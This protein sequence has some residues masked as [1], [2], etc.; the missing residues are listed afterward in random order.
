MTLR[1]VVIHLRLPFSLFLLPVYL[2]GLFLPSAAGGIDALLVGIALHLFLYPASNAFNSFYDRD[3]GPI[4]GIASPPPV[5]G[6]LL[7]VSLIWE[8]PG[9]MLL[10]LAGLWPG[11]LGLLYSLFSK[12]YS[13]DLTRWKRFPVFSLT[14]IALVQGGL[15]VLMVNFP[16]WSETSAGIL[17]AAS[18]TAALF[19]SGVYPL[20]QIYQHDADAAR[21]DC[22]YSMKVGVRGTFIHSG[23]SFLLAGGGFALVFH[24]AQPA[25]WRRELIFLLLSLAPA[26]VYFSGWAAK[27]WHD[28]KFADY[29]HAM[30]M[31]FLSSGCLNLFLIAAFILRHR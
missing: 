26:M 3:T 29:A 13:W 5:D 8:L 28:Q 18:L 23:I 15:V 17:A 24:L 20:T 25:L 6:T 4:G 31:N 21:G 1:S 11:C 10:F 9:L 30:K 12:A 14:G 2:F 19:L 16:P 7:A 27:V 22:S